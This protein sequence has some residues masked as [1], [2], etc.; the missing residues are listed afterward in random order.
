VD[1]AFVK[2]IC[3]LTNAYT[4]KPQVP[5]IPMVCQDVKRGAQA[6]Q[7]IDENAAGNR[8]GSDRSDDQ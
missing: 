6:V 1:F 7:D 3:S 5:Y 8:D 2:K 4:S